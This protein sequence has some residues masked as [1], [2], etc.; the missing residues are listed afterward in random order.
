MDI[1]NHKTDSR[2]IQSE[3]FNRDN[4]RGMNTVQHLHEDGCVSWETWQDKAVV[5]AILD[6]NKEAQKHNFDPKSEMRHVASIPAEIEVKWI[7]E[8][9]DVN[10]LTDFD[11]L[12]RK[13]NDPEWAYLKRTPLVI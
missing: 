9:G 2:V 4:T 5:Q 11:F 1:L 10:I 8:T 12:K 13:L 6:D 7:H 3:T